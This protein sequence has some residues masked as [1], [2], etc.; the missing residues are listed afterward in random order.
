MTSS[1]PTNAPSVPRKRPP[2]RVVEVRR[3]TQLTPHMVRITFG[4]EQMAGFESKG[5]AQHIRVYMPD[6]ETGE[7]LLPIK[8]PEGYAYPEDR[9][10]PATRAYTVRRWDSGT[11]E[12][13]IDIVL[14]D[15]GPGPAWAAGLKEGDVAVIIG[16]P[17]RTYFPDMDVDW[18]L[19]GGD[20]AALPAIG[21]LLE[22]LPSSIRAYVLAEVRD[23]DAELELESAAALQLRWLHGQE[24]ET[25]GRALA[26]AMREA[27]LPK[28][29]GFVWV[30]CEASIMREIRRHFIKERGFDRSILRTLGYWKAGAVDYHDKG[31]DL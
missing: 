1:I 8:R 6:S 7:L 5:P 23:A 28:G 18:Y 15:G 19:I 31:I 2:P 10:Q 22:A 14:H 11:R 13:D 29:K 20:E 3:V 16:P 26:A 21:T 27:E 4:G 17:P 30:T 9:Q 25:Q 24:G 12:L